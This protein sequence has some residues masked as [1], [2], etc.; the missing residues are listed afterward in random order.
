M[1]AAIKSEGVTILRKVVHI[2]PG[3]TNYISMKQGVLKSLVFEL[4]RQKLL[5]SDAIRFPKPYCTTFIEAP[6]IISYMYF[7]ITL[8]PAGPQ[9]TT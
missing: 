1:I 2:S 8:L 7:T 3:L 5:T 6:C 4:W 9:A